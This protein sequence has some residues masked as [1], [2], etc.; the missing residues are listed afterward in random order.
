MYRMNINC[1]KAIIIEAVY[2]NILLG[3]LCKEE[4]DGHV[5][6]GG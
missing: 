1:I 2:F 4:A 6:T 5:L 3:A